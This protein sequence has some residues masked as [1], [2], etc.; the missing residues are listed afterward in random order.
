[1]ERIE[2]FY[3]TAKVADILFVPKKIRGRDNLTVAEIAI[4]AYFN[5]ACYILH[6]RYDLF[7]Y[8][9]LYAF[10]QLARAATITLSLNEKKRFYLREERIYL[11]N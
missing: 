7:K 8:P 10:K 4:E 2:S 9:F 11:I 6:N 5:S 3:I 1:L